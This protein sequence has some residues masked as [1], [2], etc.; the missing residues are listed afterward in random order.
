MRENQEVSF[1]QNRD[2]MLG[3]I[4]VPISANRDL[5]LISA[6]KR[7][8]TGEQSIFGKA[9]IDGLFYGDILINITPDLLRVYGFQDFDTL[10]L[11]KGDYVIIKNFIGGS[12]RGKINFNNGYSDY[13]LGVRS[14]VKLEIKNINYK[15]GL[16]SEVTLMDRH[17]GQH[18]SPFISFEVRY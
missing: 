12:M 8:T 3:M 2:I 14:G 5:K 15:V 1:P 4:F 6:T 18:Q 10:T 7:Y 17:V 13:S 11:R 16:D 9:G